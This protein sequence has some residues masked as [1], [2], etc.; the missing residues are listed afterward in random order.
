MADFSFFLAGYTYGF[1][2]GKVPNFVKQG[3]GTPGKRRQRAGFNTGLTT[4]P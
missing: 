3:V 2:L 1:T 4:N